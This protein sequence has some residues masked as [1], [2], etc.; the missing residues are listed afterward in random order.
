[1]GY[2]S[3]AKIAPCTVSIELKLLYN[4]RKL[5]MLCK[6]SG[7]CKCICN[8]KVR[9]RGEYSVVRLLRMLFKKQ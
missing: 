5:F 2:V 6:M 1:M 7:L 4:G 3:T 9:V 8:L